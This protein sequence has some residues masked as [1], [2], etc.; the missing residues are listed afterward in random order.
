MVFR[1]ERDGFQFRFR[2]GTK[3]RKKAQTGNDEGNQ[4]KGNWL[5]HVNP[6]CFW[7]PHTY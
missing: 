3:G 2:F 4:H 6:P 5:F 1:Q 7:A